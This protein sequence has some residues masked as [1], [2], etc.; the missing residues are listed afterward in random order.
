MIYGVLY[1]NLPQKS[2]SYFGLYRTSNPGNQKASTVR[3]IR[4]SFQRCTSR[5]WRVE[6]GGAENSG[7]PLFR[8]RFSFAV[9]MEK[10]STM[11]LN[12]YTILELNSAKTKL[13]RIETSLA[14]LHSKVS[15]ASSTAPLSLPAMS[16]PAPLTSSAPRLD[17]QSQRGSN[18]EDGDPTYQCIASDTLRLYRKN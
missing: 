5:E 7:R 8:A 17:S 10:M 6:E 18:V 12:D 15:S 9:V 11:L 1:L 2:E 3:P 4:P 13:A 14:V 16:S